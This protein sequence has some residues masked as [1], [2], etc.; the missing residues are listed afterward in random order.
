MAKAFSKREK[1]AIRNAFLEKGKK[2]FSQYGLKKTSIDDFTKAVNVAKG[3]FYSFFE[4]KEELF[5]EILCYEGTLRKKFIDDLLASN[6]SAKQCLKIVMKS[7]SDI[8]V[9]H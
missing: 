5:L 3:T 9:D 8:E 2:L 6:R 4:S 1:D 7:V